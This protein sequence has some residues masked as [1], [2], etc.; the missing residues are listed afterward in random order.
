SADQFTASYYKAIK[1]FRANFSRVSDM[2]LG[3]LAGDLKRKE[4][5]SGRL[6]DIHAHLFIA[7][8][9]LKYYEAGQKTEAEQLHAKL[10]LQK[11][12]LNIQEAFWGL[13]D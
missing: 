9:I 4:M 6:A 10:A 8:E 5:L 1:R 11:A 7:T 3:L 13:F 2:A 12:F